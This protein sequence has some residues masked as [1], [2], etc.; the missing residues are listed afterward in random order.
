MPDHPDP[1]LFFLACIFSGAG[2]AL[3]LSDD[4][5]DMTHDIWYIIGA[6]VIAL[7]PVY[8]IG[9]LLYRAYKYYRYERLNN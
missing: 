6:S 3:G 7:Y 9:K 1:L 5:I 8:G 2:F 4:E